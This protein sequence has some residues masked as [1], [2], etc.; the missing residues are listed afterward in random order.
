MI[1]GFTILT[2]MLEFTLEKWLLRFFLFIN[3]KDK[4]LGH[5]INKNLEG[6]RKRNGKTAFMYQ[7]A[8]SFLIFAGSGFKLQ[9][10]MI[11][12]VIK[13]K[14]GCDITVRIIGD[15]TGI[16]E[17]NMRDYIESYKKVFPDRI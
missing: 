5:V 7:L 1:F 9:G 8:L 10:E 4:N 12:D 13:S 16:D 17:K 3:K 6:H 2:G 11:T 15:P 14:G